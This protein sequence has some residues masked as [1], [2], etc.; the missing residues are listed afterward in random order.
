MESPLQSRPQVHPAQPLPVLLSEGRGSSLPTPPSSHAPSSDFLHHGFCWASAY[1]QWQWQLQVFLWP[2]ELGRNSC[3]CG[4]PSMGPAG[5]AGR[6]RKWR[7][8]GLGSLTPLHCVREHLQWTEVASGPG[9]SGSDPAPQGP[10]AG[11]AAD[12]V[13]SAP[14]TA[15]VWACSLGARC[16]HTDSSTSLA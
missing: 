12:L 15:E 11:G 3:S 10:T 5:R 16:G 4:V 7:A 8:S 6:P 14:T 13:P 1:S 2:L 9:P